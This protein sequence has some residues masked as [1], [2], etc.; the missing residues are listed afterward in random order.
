[1]NLAYGSMSSEVDF[2]N[3]PGLILANDVK[4][5]MSLLAH[6]ILWKSARQTQTLLIYRNQGRNSF[7]LFSFATFSNKV[8]KACF[9]V[10]HNYDARRRALLQVYFDNTAT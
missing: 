2:D 1:M 4:Q 7:G 3:Y 6:G 9:V 5:A 8:I 10:Y